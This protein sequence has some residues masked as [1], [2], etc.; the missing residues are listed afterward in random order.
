MANL[1]AA[2]ATE[3]VTPDWV[4]DRLSTLSC[5]LILIVISD[6]SCLAIYV[7]LFRVTSL[8]PARRVPHKVRSSFFYSYE[9]LTV[10]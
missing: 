9:L 7:E 8:D 5:P 1:Q 6:G 4:D 10:P 2:Y 3:H